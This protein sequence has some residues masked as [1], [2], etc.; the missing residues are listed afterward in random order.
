MGMSVHLLVFVRLCLLWKPSLKALVNHWPHH[1]VWK[2]VSLQQT[3]DGWS[4][5]K[6]RLVRNSHGLRVLQNPLQEQRQEPAPA[7]TF[8]AGH[9]ARASAEEQMVPTV[10][11]RTSLLPDDIW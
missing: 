7:T 6:E 1:W 9:P 5:K 4:G 10:P 11:G 2:A 3:A 8:P